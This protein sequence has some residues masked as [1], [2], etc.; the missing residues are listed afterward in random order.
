MVLDCPFKAAGKRLMPS[1]QIRLLT[2]Q[3]SSADIIRLWLERS[4]SKVPLDIEIYLRVNNKGSSEAVSRPRP[5]SPT[6]GHS[7]PPHQSVGGHYVIPHPPH[8]ST[9]I[10]ILPPAHTPIIVPPPPSTY[11]AWPSSPGSP[12]E[13]SF[14]PSR[15]CMHWGYIVVYY[16]VQQMHRW[17][18]FVFRFDKHFP[19]MSALKAISGAWPWRCQLSI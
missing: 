14:P 2:T 10:P 15:T 18:R 12:T 19:S 9:T 1:P 17:E 4:G 13:K 8:P 11:D 16:L 3:N 6:W 7:F 5:A